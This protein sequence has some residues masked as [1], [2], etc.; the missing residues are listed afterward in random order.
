MRVIPAAF[1]ILLLSAGNTKNA[2]GMSGDSD[3][4]TAKSKM[5]F[6]V[7]TGL[8]AQMALGGVVGGAVVLSAPLVLS[9]VGFSGVGPVAGTVAAKCMAGAAVTGGIKAGSSYALIQSA[10][11]TGAVI[12]A[13]SI[14]IGGITGSGIA[15]VNSLR[16]VFFAENDKA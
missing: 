7:P 1:L 4:K 15:A 2:F 5:P 16:K 12:S 3:S 9:A 10:T 13:K 14:A 6:A 11:M 8:V